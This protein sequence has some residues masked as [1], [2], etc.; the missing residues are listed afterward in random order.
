MKKLVLLIVLLLLSQEALAEIILD[1]PSRDKLNAGE[2][3]ILTGYLKEPK[4]AVFTLKFTLKCRQDQQLLV[5]SISVSK[6]VRKDFSE[7]VILPTTAEGLCAI[8]SE[9]VSGEIRD[10]ALSRQFTITKEIDGNFQLDRDSIKLGEPL[11]IKGNIMRLDSSPV[12]G[13]AIIRFIQEDS[14]YFSAVVPVTNGKLDYTFNSR[15]NPSGEY[16]VE[17]EVS[18]VMGNH[19]VFSAG[20]FSIISEI[21]LV[22]E[23]DKLHVLP[24]DKVKLFGEASIAETPVDKGK[25]RID[26]FDMQKE[27][28]ISRGAFTTTLT[29]PSDA[30]AGQHDIIVFVSDEF[31]NTGSFTP[32]IIIDQYPRKLEI[33]LN[34]NELQPGEIVIV[35]PVLKDQTEKIIP[36]DITLKIFTPDKKE[37]LAGLIKSGSEY[38]FSLLNTALPGIWRIEASTPDLKESA[39]FVVGELRS[40]SYDLKDQKIHVTNIGNIKFK[41]S[42]EIVIENAERAST[43]IKEISADVNETVAIS[44][45]GHVSSGDYDVKVA[46]KVFKN[47]HLEGKKES[48]FS[49]AAYL[50]AFIAIVLVL[51]LFVALKSW[52]FKRRFHRTIRTGH[53]N[54]RH[55]D[56]RYVHIS[57]INRDENSKPMKFKFKRSGDNQ[58]MFDLPKKRSAHYPE[59]AS[60]NK[61]DKN[62]GGGLFNMFG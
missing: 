31:G 35:T 10:Q 54:K 19:Q 6:N 57:N 9:A 49:W 14:I 13:T 20:S 36:T 7:S 23:V 38:E 32:R 2:E 1:S 12:S 59:S 43:L 61:K 27:I 28:D 4:D 56:S 30:E 18:E 62:D 22:A 17:V 21:T 45:Q 29:I 26:F 40:L 15:E 55:D 60:Y 33:S 8:Q 47:V 5:R 41:G 11:K 24:N 37:V 44:L 34:K 39:T 50:I 51:L 53:I 16:S 3:V 46:D 58:L 52:S 48:S 42:L 25:V